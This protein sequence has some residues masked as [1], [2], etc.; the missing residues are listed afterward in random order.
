V[1]GTGDQYL[2][3]FKKLEKSVTWDSENKVP[4]FNYLDNNAHRH[5]VYFENAASTAV[6]DDMY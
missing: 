4:Y 1:W 2:L 6:F 3:P 5:K